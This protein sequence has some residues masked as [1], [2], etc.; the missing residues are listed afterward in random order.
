M[1]SVTVP[2]LLFL[3]LFANIIVY[4]LAVLLFVLAI[5]ICFS[6]KYI[7]VV[8]IFYGIYCSYFG[9]SSDLLSENPSVDAHFLENVAID[10]FRSEDELILSFH[11]L[12]II[13]QSFVMSSGS[14]LIRK[15]VLTECKIK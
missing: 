6:E 12:S 14:S 4:V 2:V 3:Y 10:K 15:L 1:T 13:P 11:N 9:C 8:D 5:I 7:L